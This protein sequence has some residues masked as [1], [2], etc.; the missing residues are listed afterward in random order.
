MQVNY[1]PHQCRALYEE[2]EFLD[3]QISDLEGLIAALE[4]VVY[5]LSSATI[6]DRE[7]AN[8]CTAIIGISTALDAS[9]KR[10]FESEVA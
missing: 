7:V 9:V 6:R 2:R 10:R 5:D 8:L 3:R 1:T 4:L